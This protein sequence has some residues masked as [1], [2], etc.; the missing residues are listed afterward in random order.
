MCFELNQAY[1]LSRRNI[2]MF[3]EVHGGGAAGEFSD[4]FGPEKLGQHSSWAAGKPLPKATKLV[5][6]TTAAY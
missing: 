2:K 1:E 3:L 5:L 6:W 4:Y